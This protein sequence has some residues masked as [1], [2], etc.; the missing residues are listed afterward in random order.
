ML[1]QRARLALE[2]HFLGARP[3]QHCLQSLHELAQLRRAQIRRR[4]AAE[5]DVVQRPAADERNATVQRH[6]LDE[7]VEVGFDIA[8]VLVGVDAE[9]AELAA[10]AAERNVQ[11]Q[12][13]R[14]TGFGSR[15]ESG[16]S[17]G[18]MAGFQKENGG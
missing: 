6:F 17:V 11:I 3:R 5:V 9:I 15:V 8:G 10:F 2:R 18:Q 13:Q 16:V 7:R 4:A 12:A 1:L 14:R